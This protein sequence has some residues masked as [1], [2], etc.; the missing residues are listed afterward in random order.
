VRFLPALTI[1]EVTLQQGMDIFETT[2]RGMA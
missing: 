1:D 2:L